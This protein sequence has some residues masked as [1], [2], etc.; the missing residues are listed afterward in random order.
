MTDQITADDIPI[1]HT[2]PGGWQG[3]MPRPVLA[4][5]TEPLAADAPDLRGLWEA[6]SVE[7]DG[8][9]V[10]GHP[11]N[12]HIE[13]VE[14]CGNRVVVTAQGIIHD[15]R[16]DGTLENG[17]HDV[18]GP[19]NFSQEIR[20]AALFTDGRLDLHPFGVQPGRPPL[21][22]REVIDGEMIW[23]Y[24]PFRVTL[25]RIADPGN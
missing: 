15:M 6:I 16:A 3:E 25:R 18:A 10:P 14:Q 4:R 21:V 23:N 11:L 17:V 5:C 8:K 1:A 9:P 24:G 2:P 20:V 13:R 22:T 7:Q 12:H 19:P